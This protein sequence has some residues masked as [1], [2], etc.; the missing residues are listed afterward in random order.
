MENSWIMFDHV[1]R[2]KDWITIAC[3]VYDSRYCKIL[4]IACCDMQSEDDTTQTFFWNNLNVVMAKNSVSKV[5]FKGFKADN[6]Q[7]NWNA[8]RMVYGDGDPTLRMVAR[9]HTCLLHWYASLD[10]VTQS[11]SNHYCNFN[12]NNFARIIKMQKQWTMLGL[13]SISFVLG[14]CHPE[15]P[16]RKAFS[17]FYSGWDFGISFTDNGWSYAPCKCIVIYIIQ[18]H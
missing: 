5:N 14:G 1:K 12:T 13:S 4:T 3:H 15:L 7:V 16:Q 17:I 2:V 10:K 6:A 18:C 8:V 9:E 11:I